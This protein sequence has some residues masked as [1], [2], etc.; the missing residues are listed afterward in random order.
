MKA[1]LFTILFLLCLLFASARHTTIADYLNLPDTPYN[2]AI[3]LPSYFT[4]NAGSPLP[5]SING[6][7]NTPATNPITNDGATLGR[8]LFYDKNLSLNRTVACASCHQQ[9]KGFS[10][11]RVLSVGFLGGTTR[12]HS[13]TLIDAKYYQRGRF[14]WDERAS[15]L[16]VQVLQPFQDTTEMGLT[17]AQITE[18]VAEQSYYNQLFVNAFGNNTITTDRV[19]K[20]LAQ[21][22]RSIESYQSK[23]DVGR[24]LV[25]APGN[26]FPNFT[27]Q[28][29]QGKNLFFQ[30]IANGGGG[31]V[32]C[33]TTEA[34]VSAN[35]GTQNNGLD[36]AST[37][38][39][40]A[41][42]VFP[43]AI[44]VGRF[45]TSTLRNIEL[46]APYMHDGRF[47]TLEQ[48]VEHYNSGVQNH[49]TLA[50]A[51]KT[52]QGTPVRLNFSVAQKAALVAFLKTLTD[53]TIATEPRWSNPFLPCNADLSLTGTVNSGT[54][55]SSNTISIQNGANQTNSN[56]TIE[57][58]NTVQLTPPFEVKSGNSF[59]V[60]TGGCN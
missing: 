42:E 21:F 16:E 26:N 17:L 54:Y 4:T 36:A 52:P 27:A 44:F 33:H 31:C 25:A 35:G 6:L 15:T 43:Q 30:P 11:D 55:K 56:I 39:L 49:P 48:V 53:N 28:E 51:L 58:K 19:S 9:D 23:Y 40:G 22:V 18:R 59:K 10:D 29:N 50:N 37:T 5:T 57:A 46:T 20:A 1:K 24:A 12:R 47:T 13:M 34:F 8:V 7:D 14:F 38:D 45:K 60:Q 3:T 41:G 32:G 2:Y